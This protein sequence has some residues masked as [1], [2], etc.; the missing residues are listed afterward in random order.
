MKVEI[1]NI[2]IKVN[3]KTL[4]LSLKETEVLFNELNK[5][6]GP[7]YNYG[8]YYPYNL[9]TSGTLTINNGDLN[10]F[11]PVTSGSVITTL[12]DSN[13]VTF[14]TTNTEINLDKN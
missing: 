8:P 1:G 9:A 6:F 3:K 2:K 7:R 13:P 5:V 14:T 4:T 11:N 12:S 10:K